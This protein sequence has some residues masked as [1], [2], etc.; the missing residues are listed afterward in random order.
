MST[1][2]VG[3]V[4]CQHSEVRPTHIE[5]ELWNSR[6]LTKTEFREKFP[7]YDGECPSCKKKLI[8]Y[9]SYLHYVRGA[10]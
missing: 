6:E 8:L 7:R 3:D 5:T 1:E 2:I 4:M 10:W 9:S